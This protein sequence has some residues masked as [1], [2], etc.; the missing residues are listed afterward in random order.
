MADSMNDPPKCEPKYTSQVNVKV[1]AGA[2][3]DALRT[4]DKNK[5]FS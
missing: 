3:A 5:P 2:S 4:R 1:L